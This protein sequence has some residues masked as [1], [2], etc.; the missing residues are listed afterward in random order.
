MEIPTEGEEILARENYHKSALYKTIQKIKPDILI[1]DLLWFSLFHFIE[2][3]QCKKIFLCHQ[4]SDDFF[5]IPTSEEE[6]IF[7]PL[8]YNEVLAIEPFESV[9]QMR[10][11]NPI[12][13]RNR[14]E[15]FSR[16]EALNK[17]NLKGEK[18]ICLFAFNGR[19]ED[20]DRNKQKYS[21]L[22]NAGYQMVYTTNYKGGLFPVLDYFNAFDFIICGAGYNQFWE[23][24]YFQKEAVFENV[25]LRFSST[26]KRIAQCSDF[27]FDENGADQLVNLLQAL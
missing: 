13:L 3:L 23:V 6:L 8:V 4:V 11:I 17:L 21:Y 27:V 15:V 14:D 19:P 9:I 16:E 24:Q 18:D 1:V 10:E 22:E 25:P 2:E 20:F 12:I 7:N 5:Q 26:E